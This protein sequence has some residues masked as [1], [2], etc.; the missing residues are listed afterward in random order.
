MRVITRPQMYL[1][2]SYDLSCGLLP[3]LAYLY[4]LGIEHHRI[5]AGYLASKGRIEKASKI[6][7]QLFSKACNNAASRCEE[8]LGD[9]LLAYRTSV[10][11]TTVYVSA[12]M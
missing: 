6:I 8:K 7:K 2:L 12:L 1:F 11:I 10:S 3:F 4:S 5:T 9:V